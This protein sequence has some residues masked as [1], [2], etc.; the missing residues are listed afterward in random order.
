MNDAMHDQTVPTA[1]DANGDLGYLLTAY[2]DGQLALEGMAWVEE[3][4][5]RRP[6]L[7]ARLKEIR[8][9]QAAL[10]A[11]FAR[12]PAPEELG[13]FARGQ[14]L[15]AARRGRPFFRQRG[16]QAALVMI[17]IGIAAMA[18]AAVF[19]LPAS[20]VHG[21]RSYASS[22]PA[23]APIQKLETPRGVYDPGEYAM[24]IDRPSAGE[25]RE[26]DQLETVPDRDGSTTADE[27]GDVAK[28]REE[29]LNEADTASGHGAFMALGAGGGTSGGRRSKHKPGEPPAAPGAA[30]TEQLARAEQVVEARDFQGHA[31]PLQKDAGEVSASDRMVE[32]MAQAVE[33]PAAAAKPEQVV[34]TEGHFG[35][36]KRLVA[37]SGHH[38]AT[39]LPAPVG[40]PQPLA[41]VNAS[42][43]SED[44][45][46]NRE[47]QSRQAAAESMYD[48]K[49]S[50]VGGG[51][52][53]L[54]PARPSS[55]PAVA[56]NGTTSVVATPPAS[57]TIALPAKPG[58]TKSSAGAVGG[59]AYSAEQSAAKTGDLKAARTA[60]TE[61]THIAEVGRAV[62]FQLNGKLAEV[63][64]GLNRAKQQGLD[65]QR[66]GAP[67][68][69]P[70]QIGLADQEY[71]QLSASANKDRLPYLN[72]PDPLA[73]FSEPLPESHEQAQAMQ[74][75]DD[76]R[77]IAKLDIVRERYPKVF[78]SFSDEHQSAAFFQATV[79]SVRSN[80]QGE[81]EGDLVMLTVGKQDAVDAGT[82]FI[83]FRGSQY[84]VKVRA[85]KV[86]NGMVAC[87]VIPGSWNANGAQIQMGDLAQNRLGG[88][89]DV[90]RPATSDQ[91]SSPSQALATGNAQR[92][93][94]DRVAALL[95]TTSLNATAPLATI[96]RLA[97]GPDGALAASPA[98]DEVL[99]RPAHLETHDLTS[100]QALLQL[101]RGAGLQA[102]LL[103][104]VL[105]LDT[106]RGQ[107]DPTDTQGLDRARFT[108][109]FGTVPM[110][111]T[112]EDARSTF[113]LDANT[114]SFERARSQLRSG[115]LPDPA[116]IQAEH[117]INAMPMDYP[118]AR[119]P[120]AFALYAEA[121]PSP[122][123]LG[124][125]DAAVRAPWAGRTAVVAIGAV[126]RPAAPDERRPL[127]L[128]LALDCSGS[129][130]QPGGLDRVRLGLEELL[131]HLRPVD[132]VAVVAFSDQARVVLPATPGGDSAPIARALAGLT[133]GGATNAVEGLALA[134]QLAAEHL[135]PG[136]ENRVLFATDGGTLAGADAQVVIERVAAYRSR[137]ISL[138]VVGCGG[139]AYQGRT[140][141]QLAD[142]A[143][144]QH[145]FLGSDADAVSAFASRLLPE[146][147]AV[148]A[149]D[150]KVQVTWNPQRV[151]HF[152]LIGY[153]QRRLAH[154]DFRN[155]AVDAGEI[156]HDTQVTALYEVLLVDGA[157]G[158]LGSAAVRYFDTRLQQV[159]ELSCPLAGAVLQAEPGE[160][161]R[162][163]ACAAEF[164]AWLQRGWW[165]NVRPTTPAR[166]LGEL[167][168][169]PQAEARELEELVQRAAALQPQPVPIPL[170]RNALQSNT[171]NA[172]APTDQA[173]PK[174]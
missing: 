33:P 49:K 104:G 1:A 78:N 77:S 157:T 170:N 54:P 153:E 123:A 19:G 100:G 35:G 20:V 114:A 131:T 109:A 56:A 46:R 31:A 134:Y 149:K 13:G 102:R 96:L 145:V 166:L 29:T 75:A 156:S 63:E 64:D 72:V 61:K 15:D 11:E 89:D 17:S 12:F 103:G 162:L 151:S 21:T 101:A 98:L 73:T 171:L 92:A 111:A 173:A 70:A 6:E 23:S 152:R 99:T 119:G 113:A 135:E 95:T 9:V 169:C 57:S 22:Q 88:S 47:L 90:E 37:A 60:H 43:S 167:A 81:G 141:Q 44:K 83:V 120:E 160:R 26:T 74:T 138:L 165:S 172:A 50:S 147:L 4:L 71:R 85:E 76:D 105:T 25:S 164:A 55:P 133:P 27:D 126:A 122:F 30:P 65:G 130:A 116:A 137:G 129:M 41:G 68:A 80:P 128:T 7:R 94:R 110:V 163:V 107:L 82:E 16:A 91:S 39:D 34:V 87:R 125:A 124:P 158:P 32:E 28:G 115:Q 5:D 118:A 14:V 108:S 8:A 62:A 53:K 121:A 106:A 59:I 18:A 127:H 58:S 148:L 45:T 52:G 161:L 155:D 2:A 139:G 132:T 136:T 10:R 97:A 42:R 154:Q 3:Q 143:D 86:L 146:R 69:A 66:D 174:P 93:P 24:I 117:F 84:I 48:A 67:S 150:A 51:D 40:A 159:R 168:H 36:G 79:S 38:G 112:A 140:L 144:G 142:R